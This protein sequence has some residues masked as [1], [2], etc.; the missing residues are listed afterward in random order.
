MTT[1]PR[2]PKAAG[3]AAAR[4]TPRPA[5]RPPPRPDLKLAADVVED[6]LLSG[7]LT[8]RQLKR[9]HKAGTDAVLLASAVPALEGRRVVDLGAGVGTVGLILA[10]RFPRARVTLVDNDA[11]LVGLA[12]DNILL[13]GFQRRV[14][15]IAADVFASPAQRRARGL[16]PESFDCVVTNPPWLDGRRFRVSP[17]KGKASAHVLEGGTLDDWLKTAADLLVPRG[18][19][20]VVYRADGLPLLLA[21]MAGRFG[22]IV[23][24][25]VQ[26]R[27]DRLATRIIIH[28]VKG[29]RSPLAIASPLV[30]HDEDNRF[31]P[32]AEAIH[33]DAGGMQTDDG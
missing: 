6:R 3:R 12:E 22:G 31:T 23:L 5:E 16:L 30:L 10:A 20:M 24:R 4:Q 9:G 27:E 15:A 11:R 8:V 26:P 33:R 1:K 14:G 7:T 13:N 21:A 25:P 32:E 29:S 19:L 18:D 28:A 2:R 17:D